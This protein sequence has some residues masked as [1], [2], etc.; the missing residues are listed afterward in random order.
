MSDFAAHEP[1][2]TGSGEVIYPHVLRSVVERVVEGEKKYGTFLRANNGRNAPMDAVQ[3]AVDLLMY[4]HQWLI[5]REQLM[6]RIRDLENKLREV[7]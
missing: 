4:M 6:S 2:P 1:P 5:E 3:E 7:G